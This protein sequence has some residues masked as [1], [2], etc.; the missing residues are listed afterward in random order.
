[1]SVRRQLRAALVRRRHEQWF[2][3]KLAADRQQKDVTR[4]FRLNAN[5]ENGIGIGPRGCR[6]VVDRSCRH[7]PRFAAAVGSRP[8]G[9]I[10]AA[11]DDTSAINR[12]SGE[13]GSGRRCSEPGARAPQEIE[14]FDDVRLTLDQKPPSVGR[15]PWVRIAIGRQVEGYLR[16]VTAD[17]DDALGIKI[18]RSKYQRAVG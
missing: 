13:T 7:R 4:R 16:A 12:P 18:G 6:I 1:M 5:R 15:N 2:G 10:E 11:K 8:E 9:H 14:G 17:G 3:L